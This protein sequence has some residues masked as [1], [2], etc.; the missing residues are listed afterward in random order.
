[1]YVDVDNGMACVDRGCWRIEKAKDVYTIDIDSVSNIEICNKIC[2]SCCSD[3]QR[4]G[5]ASSIKYNIYRNARISAGV[6]DDDSYF[7]KVYKIASLSENY[8][9]LGYFK[10][11]IDYDPGCRYVFDR[12][13]DKLLVGGD[14]YD[15]FKTFIQ[16]THEEDIPLIMK[17]TVGLSDECKNYLLFNVKLKSVLKKLDREKKRTSGE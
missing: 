15:T 12:V 5:I 8:T 16:R 7:I 3:K 9:S 1:L 6:E 10:Y 14:D 13:K 11:I 4:N 17:D 2:P